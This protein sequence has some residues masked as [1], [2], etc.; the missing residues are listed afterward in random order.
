MTKYEVRIEFI[1]GQ[2]LDIE[3]ATGY[4]YDEKSNSYYVVKNDM[5]QFFNK[6][7]VKYI[8]RIADLENY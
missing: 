3:D 1:D 2:T 5:R 4:G 8:G 6:E 7:Q